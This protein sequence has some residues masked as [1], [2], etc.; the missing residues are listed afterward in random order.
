MGWVRVRV[1]A[2]R[3]HLGMMSAHQG[4]VRTPWDGVGRSCGGFRIPWDGVGTLQGDVRT[5]EWCQ[6]TFKW[7]RLEDTL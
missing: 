4:G 1:R 5:P 3:G 7:I 2:V 6:D